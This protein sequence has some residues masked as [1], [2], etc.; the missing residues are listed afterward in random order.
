[1]CNILFQYV[2]N[3]TACLILLKCSF[4]IAKYC[5]IKWFFS[6]LDQRSQRVRAGNSHS[7]WLPLNGAMPQGSWLGP[8]TFFII[9]I[10]METYKAPLTMA[11]RRRTVHA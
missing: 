1:M 8:L 4:N 9:I 10:I 11:Q 7:T 2:A 5:L 6:Y 3:L